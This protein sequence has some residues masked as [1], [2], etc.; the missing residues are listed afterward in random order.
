MWCF[1]LG[2]GGLAQ[3]LA[4]MW[5]ANRGKLFGAMVFTTYG[6]FWLSLGLFGILAD[7]RPRPEPLKRHRP[8]WAHLR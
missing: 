4:G 8:P 7:V 2:Y 3:L 6:A 5:E 1:A